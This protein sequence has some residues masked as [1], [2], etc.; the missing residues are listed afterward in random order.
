MSDLFHKDVPFEFIA[1]V[2]GVMGACPQH[3]FQV[4]TKRP[5]RA[6]EFFEWV[7]GRNI[8]DIACKYLDNVGF[9]TGCGAALDCDEGWPLPNV[10]LGTSVEDQPTAD[11]RIPHL[12]K[13]PAAV[14]W[15]SYE[16]ALGPVSLRA[17]M[18]KQKDADIDG[19]LATPDG[20]VHVDDWNV[21]I[22]WVVVGGESGSGAR[23]MHPDWARNIRG[24]CQAAGVPM[25]F[26]QW[27]AWAPRGKRVDAH[28]NAIT[29]D[30]P[31]TLDSQFPEGK[32]WIAYCHDGT[33]L[34]Q[35][36]KKKAGRLLDGQAWDQ[37]PV[38]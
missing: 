10:W 4:L 5:E 25:L 3:V 26:K 14:R 15:V 33:V 23:P 16:P 38:A 11:E 27:G 6:V 37:Y 22:H 12:L 18:L 30:K 34:M 1:A 13:C 32:N 31:I 21:A 17:A 20:P 8:A 24:Q 29:R 19:F 35:V 36:G 7:E 28:G 9:E 2:F